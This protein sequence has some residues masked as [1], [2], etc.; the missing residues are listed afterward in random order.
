MENGGMRSDSALPFSCPPV[1][2]KD[3]VEG[4]SERKITEGD[5]NRWVGRRRDEIQGEKK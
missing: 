1:F 3:S 2:Q 4:S 5:G